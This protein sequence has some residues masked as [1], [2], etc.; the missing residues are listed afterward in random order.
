MRPKDVHV[1]WAG[2]VPPGQP[3]NPFHI[4]LPPMAAALLSVLMEYPAVQEE[5]RK[6]PRAYASLVILQGK[7]NAALRHDASQN[8]AHF[9]NPPLPDDRP[10]GRAAKHAI[11]DSIDRVP[12]PGPSST[13]ID[14]ARVRM[15]EDNSERVRREPVQYR[16]GRARIPF[17]PGEAR[18]PSSLGDLGVHMPSSGSMR[19]VE[20]KGFF[21]DF[22]G[23]AND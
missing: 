12:E 9:D 14:S 1:E 20:G 2:A 6:H 7:I 15:P 4:E 10:S 22:G 17:P 5:A 13:R 21:L 18:I 19:H 16:P 3:L 23:Q 11:R 8:P